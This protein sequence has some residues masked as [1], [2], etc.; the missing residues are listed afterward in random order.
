MVHHTT[1]G[2]KNC[3][4]A[5]YSLLFME[6]DNAFVIMWEV[7]FSLDRKCHVII[8]VFQVG[9]LSPVPE[10][11]MSTEDISIITTDEF[12]FSACGFP[13]KLVGLPHV[14]GSTILVE[15]V[16]GNHYRVDIPPLC[17][18]ELGKCL[19]YYDKED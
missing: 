5:T 4:I 7:T 16:G 3:S 9:H 15:L 12:A 19:K 1:A 17:S 11:A 6:L 10:L 13:S 2:E 18:T 14:V 8:L